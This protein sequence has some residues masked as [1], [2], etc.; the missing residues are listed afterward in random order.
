MTNEEK[1]LILFTESLSK[2]IEE[3]AK[4]LT[5]IEAAAFLSVTSGTIHKMAMNRLIPYYKPNGKTLYFK[6][7]ELIKYLEQNRVQPKTEVEALAN[8]Y[9]LNGKVRQ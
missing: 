8:R 6:K 7:S 5:R 1:N 9:L 2:L 4:P 3:S